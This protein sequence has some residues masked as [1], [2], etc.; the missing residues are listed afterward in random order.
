MQADLDDRERGLYQKFSVE[1]LDGSSVPGQKHDGCVY[2]VLD[3]THDPF[4]IPALWA[5]AEACQREYPKLAKD[6]VDMAAAATR[7]NSDLP[8]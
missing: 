7:A 4:A 8:E 5:Y 6:L 3:I 2:F 1:R